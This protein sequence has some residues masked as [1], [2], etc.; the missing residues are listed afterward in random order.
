MPPGGTSSAISLKPLKAAIHVFTTHL[1]RPA[2]LGD[3]SAET[4]NAW[5][6]SQMERV[7]RRTCKNY[8]ASLMTLWRWAFDEQ[9]VEAAPLRVRLVSAPL[10]PVAAFTREEVQRLLEACDALDDKFCRG[11]VPRR[12][13]YRALIMVAW[14]TGFR[15]GDIMRLRWADVAQNGCVQIVQHKTGYPV[16]RWLNTTTIAALEKIRLKDEPRIFRGHTSL[17]TWR[18]VFRGLKLEAGI[19]RGAIKWIRRAVATQLAIA[20]GESV[21]SHALGHRTADMARKHYLDNSQITTGQVLMDA[22][23]VG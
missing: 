19:S 11:R 17:E 13:L 3:L 10:P 20:H 7:A 14:D 15:P 8:R 18:F 4:I 1:G 12:L 6:G 2:C 22:L 21:A 9:L 5:L 23:D 16:T